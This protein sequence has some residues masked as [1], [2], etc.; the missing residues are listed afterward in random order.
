M[1]PEL[2]KT[3]PISECVDGRLYRV[4]TRNLLSHCVYRARDKTFLGIREK[5][6]NT[7]LC[8]EYHWGNGAPFG[9]ASP[10]EDMG[11][12]LPE[13]L[14]NREFLGDVDSITGRPIVYKM[15]EKT[16]KGLWYY[17]GTRDLAEGHATLVSNTALYE[18]LSTVTPTNA[19]ELVDIE[20]SRKHFRAK[21]KA[22]FEALQKPDL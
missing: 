3:I 9:T 1:P 18:W 17:E 10:L 20:A 12:D 7:Y 15:D 21:D 11:I 5:F 14:L 8:A 13:E 16:G 4:R 6:W 22:E 2:E 19:A